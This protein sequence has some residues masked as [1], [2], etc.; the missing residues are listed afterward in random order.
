[1]NM[2]AKIKFL[3]F[4]FQIFA[5]LA[6]GPLFAKEKIVIY[7]FEDTCATGDLGYYSTIIPSSIKAEI[8]TLDK[9]NKYTIVSQPKVI[10]FFDTSEPSNSLDSHIPKLAKMGRAQKANYLVIGSY[11]VEDDII[12]LDKSTFARSV[13]E[14]LSSLSG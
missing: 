6:A 2:K 11:F 12:K 5:V 3:L 4:I 14:S 1:M 7:H 9:D 10:K 8:K 13:R